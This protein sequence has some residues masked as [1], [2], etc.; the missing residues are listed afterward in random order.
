MEI[1]KPSPLEELGQM[2]NEAVEKDGE[3]KGH[4]S[5]VEGQTRGRVYPVTR[6]YNFLNRTV[7]EN[8]EYSS[9]W[10]LKEKA[11]LDCLEGLAKV[12]N[13]EYDLRLEVMPIR[14]KR[15]VNIKKPYSGYRGT[16]II[17]LG[18]GRH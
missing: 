9:P 13:P 5:F 8:S 10:C 4:V 1:K 12:V 2:I 15:E 3:I 6:V 14:N 16:P 7:E 17:P 18:M 11:M